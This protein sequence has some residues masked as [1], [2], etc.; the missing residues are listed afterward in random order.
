AP[1]N[2]QQILDV[3]KPV[4]LLRHSQIGAYVYPVVAAEFTNWRREQIAW[5]KTVVLYDQSHHMVNLV[6]RGPG[7]LKLITDT[8]VNST[9]SFPVGMAKQ[10]VPTTPAG[11][12][13][14][15]GILFHVNDEEFIFVG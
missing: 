3:T 15:D 1:T 6:L 12:V 14:G 11:D 10:Y 13:I 8:A 9:A 2:L 7:A 5:R 4:D